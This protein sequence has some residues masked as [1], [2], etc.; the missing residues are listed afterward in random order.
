MF[1][2][3]KK[4]QS[5]K[6]PAHM[7]FALKRLGVELKDPNIEEI[8]ICIYG[9]IQQ[10]VTG[11]EDFCKYFFGD[12][13]ILHFH[14]FRGFPYLDHPEFNNAADAQGLLTH[15]TERDFMFIW[16]VKQFLYA[17][18]DGSYQFLDINWFKENTY[19]IDKSDDLPIS[20][21][22]AEFLYW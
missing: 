14:S 5:Q 16:I 17:R 1:K 7:Y 18:K 12:T 3:T 15:Y 10:F 8:P 13:R 11:L 2:R 21:M 4:N 19:R 6:K 20:E 22:P 9:N